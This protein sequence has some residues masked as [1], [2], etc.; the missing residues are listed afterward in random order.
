MYN[1][2]YIFAKKFLITELLKKKPDQTDA[3]GILESYLC[4]PDK[5]NQVV[6][7]KILFQRLLGSAQN[8]NMKASVIGRAIAGHEKLGE[9]LSAFDPKKVDQDYANT[10]EKLLEDIRKKLNPNGKMRTAPRSIWPMYCKT[11][12]SAAKFFKQ[13]NCDKDFYDWA[14]LFYKDQRSMAALPLVL[15]A[16]IEGIGYALACDFLKELGFVNYGKPDVHIKR[17]FVGIDFC[18]PNASEYQIQKTIAQ[19]AQA[20]S[21]SAYNVDKLFWL[22]GSGNFYNHP[23]IGNIG[24]NRERFIEEFSSDVKNLKLGICSVIPQA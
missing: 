4:L 12:L 7:L 8:A 2:A 21:V 5:S 11:I 17:I 22:I 13:F 15:A 1:E 16:E 6:S 9:V 24:R 14:N 10:P 19:I 20:A 23:E 3:S 18:S